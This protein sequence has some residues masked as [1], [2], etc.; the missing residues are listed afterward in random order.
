MRTLVLVVVI[1]VVILSSQGKIRKE[2]STEY[3]WESYNHPEDVV[4]LSSQ[5]KIR[6]EIV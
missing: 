1:V 3:F 4:I 5:G 2:D 6:K